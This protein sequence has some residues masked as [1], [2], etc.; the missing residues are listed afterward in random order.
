MTKYER[1]CAA[2]D[3]II[4]DRRIIAEE[5]KL[6]YSPPSVKAVIRAADRYHMDGLYDQLF[7]DVAF[8]LEKYIDEGKIRW[9]DLQ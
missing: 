5:Y 6:P 2:L 4:E 3:S 1:I 7:M 9:E 8:I